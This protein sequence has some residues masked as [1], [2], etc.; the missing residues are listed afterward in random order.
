M[1]PNVWIFTAKQSEVL[2]VLFVNICR[3]R[4]VFFFVRWK[5]L[6]LN[7]IK[8]TITKAKTNLSIT[9]TSKTKTT[10]LDPK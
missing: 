1:K 9:T 8:I 3:N 2:C 10:F 6:L 5:I 4:S 7:L